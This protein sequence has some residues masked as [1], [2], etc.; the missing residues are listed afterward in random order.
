MPALGDGQIDSRLSWS[1]LLVMVGME[2]L[3][4]I[5]QGWHPDQHRTLSPSSHL[6][7]LTTALAFDNYCGG[8]STAPPRDAGVLEM[9]MSSWK[10]VLHNSRQHGGTSVLASSLM[11]AWANRSRPMWAEQPLNP[12]CHVGYTFSCAQR[13]SFP[14]ILLFSSLNF[15]K[16]MY[17]HQCCLHVSS[18]TMYM[19]FLWRP[20]EGS[21]SHAAGVRDLWVVM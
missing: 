1:L 11:P 3:K 4:V 18:C 13:C 17:V 15:F 20:V 21:G 7:F 5:S 16:K 2:G 8:M 10:F 6:Q 12:T 9:T 14:Q 19:H